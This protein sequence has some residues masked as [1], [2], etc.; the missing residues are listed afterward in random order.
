M[1]DF[2]TDKILD[3]YGILGAFAVVLSSVVL[4][5]LWI[6]VCVQYPV[7]ILTPVLIAGWMAWRVTGGK[8]E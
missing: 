7:A 3:R 6:V 4:L 1:S 5:I 8:D 2:I